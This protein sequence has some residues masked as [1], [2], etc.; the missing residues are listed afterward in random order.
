MMRRD[1]IWWTMGG[2][3]CDL[4]ARDTSSQ[5][6]EHRLDTTC[7]RDTSMETYMHT[8]TSQNVRSLMHRPPG[9]A[10]P[11]GRHQLFEGLW[12]VA[13]PACG[14]WEGSQ[15]VHGRQLGCVLQQAG[16]PTVVTVPTLALPPVRPG[17]TDTHGKAGCSHSLGPGRPPVA[18]DNLIDDGHLVAVLGPGAQAWE[19]G[20]GANT[21][22]S[23]V[24]CVEQRP[25]H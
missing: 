5:T 23:S 1:E 8:H 15:V 13:V 10:P 14:K 12:H 2:L 18:L 17:H 9:V 7:G 22:G 25:R 16:R 20:A 19:W 4:N 6:F 24:I 11:A 21:A 3:Q